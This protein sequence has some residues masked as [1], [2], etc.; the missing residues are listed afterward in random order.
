MTH[1]IHEHQW[2]YLADL[3]LVVSKK[4]TDVSL[5]R[6]E[7]CIECSSLRVLYPSGWYV[8]QGKATKEF[9]KQFSSDAPGEVLKAPPEEFRPKPPKPTPSRLGR[10]L[11]DLST[12]RHSYSPFKTK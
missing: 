7:Y 8:M 3:A 5:R 6:G 9:L 1:S 12:R 11:V 10:N 2:V 4:E